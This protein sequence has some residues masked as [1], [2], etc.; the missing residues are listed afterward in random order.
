MTVECPYCEHDQEVCQ[1]DGFG[2][3]EE[4]DYEMQC[5]N[6]EKYFVF[7]TSI[8]FYYHSNK[9]DCLNGGEHRLEKT[10]TYPKRFT[11]W[12]CRDCGF[13]KDLHPD[14]PLLKELE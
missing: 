11:K 3:E 12:R 4:V 13:E 7:N 9:A 10:S 2:C 5:C 8:N 1:D 6:C 14:D